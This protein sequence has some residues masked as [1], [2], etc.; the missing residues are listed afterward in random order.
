M[1][2]PAITGL[3][4]ITEGSDS[5]RFVLMVNGIISHKMQAPNYRL[6]SFQINERA[7]PEFERQ[8]LEDL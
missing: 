4:I 3:P 7:L 8:E 1:R 6:Y 5:M 2:V